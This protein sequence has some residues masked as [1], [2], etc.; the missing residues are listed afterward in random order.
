MQGTLVL[1]APPY[2]HLLLALHCVAPLLVSQSNR[3]VQPWLR[4]YQLQHPM[5]IHFHYC[6]SQ[7]HH[8]SGISAWPAP[9][10]TVLTLQT[11]AQADQVQSD[12]L[13]ITWGWGLP[14]CQG[15]VLHCFSL[16][17]ILCAE[18]RLPWGLGRRCPSLYQVFKMRASFTF[19]VRDFQKYRH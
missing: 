8:P 17:Q 13:W 11:T 9:G 6:K 7:V 10:W 19:S 16:A 1:T 4:P 5:A 12:S 14:L 15:R 18:E 3:K 2:Y